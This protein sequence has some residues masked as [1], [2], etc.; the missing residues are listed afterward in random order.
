MCLPSATEGMKTCEHT[1]TKVTVCKHDTAEVGVTAIQRPHACQMSSNSSLD[2][3]N[4]AS[5]CGE[6]GMIAQS[7]PIKFGL[8]LYRRRAQ[9]LM[10]P[11]FPAYHQNAAA[12]M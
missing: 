4:P 9:V 3:Q 8:Q 12:R 1:G 2:E 5:G 10:K 7:D 11:C 6:K